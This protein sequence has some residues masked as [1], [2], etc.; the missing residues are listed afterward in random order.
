MF[1][2]KMKDNVTYTLLHKSKIELYFK[3]YGGNICSKIKFRSKGV[4]YTGCLCMSLWCRTS[5][6]SLVVK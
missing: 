1:L 4:G 6:S 2:R 5:D 3:E